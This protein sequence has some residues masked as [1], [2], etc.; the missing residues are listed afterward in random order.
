MLEKLIKPLLKINIVSL[1]ADAALCVLSYFLSNTIN[2][3]DKMKNVVILLMLLVIPIT[4]ILLLT[5][6]KHSEIMRSSSHYY[7]F[8]TGVILIPVIGWIIIANKMTNNLDI[9]LIGYFYIIS[10]FVADLGFVCN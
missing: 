2:S 7:L 5:I 4:A 8:F 10:L 9:L 1:F 6:T 3:T